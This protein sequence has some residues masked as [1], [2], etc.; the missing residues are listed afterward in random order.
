MAMIIPSSSQE[1]SQE[2][3]EIVASQAEDHEEV[4]ETPTESATQD[5][6]QSNAEGDFNM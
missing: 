3:H 4:L 2:E 1:G 6:Q 5:S